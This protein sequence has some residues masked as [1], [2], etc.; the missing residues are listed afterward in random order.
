MGSQQF[1]RNFAIVAHIDHGKSTLADRLLEATGTIEP[2]LMMEQ[3]LDSNPIE[4]ERGITIKLAPVRMEYRYHNENYILNL[5]DTPGH[6]DFSYEV[7]RS[8]SACEGVLL[9]VDA[10]HGIQAQT[11]A[12]MKLVKEIGLKVIPIVNKIDLPAAKI[13]E[14]K[15]S[16]YQTFGFK[17]EE[18]IEVSAKKGIN[19]DKVLEEVILRIP[20]P[21]IDSG[22]QTR[23]L[24]FSSVYDPH[25]GVVIYV[26]VFNQEIKKVPLRLYASNTTFTPIELG[27]FTPQMKPANTLAAGE[28]GYVASGL[29]DLSLAKIGD[30]IGFADQ[31]FIPLPGF[32]EPKPMVFLSLYPLDNNNFLLLRQSLEK[33]HL[34][35]SSFTYTLHSSAALGKGYLC[36]FLGLLHADIMR[37]RLSREFGI[38]TIAASPS[39]EYKIKINSQATLIIHSPQDF[40][41]P[42]SIR[43]I[44]EP[45]MYTTIYTPTTT[46]GAVMQLCQEKR[47][48][49]IN[50]EYIADQAIFT[51]LIPLAEIIFDFYDLLKSLS[52]GYASLDYEFFEYRKVDAVKLDILLNREK[53]DAFSQIVVNQ[54]ADK[55]AEKLVHKLKNLIPRHQFEIPIQ[56]AIGGKII[57]RSD[58]KAFRKD[59]T[60]KLYGGDRTRKDKLLEAQKKGKKRMRQFGKVEIPQ[61]V[62]L[63]IYK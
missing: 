52:S 44:T 7:S 48:E 5:I 23:G 11:L 26:R 24:V 61:N 10:T 35:D 59:V 43:E 55:I 1:I 6:V 38:E 13:N 3:I 53:I 30:T 56:A 34:S 54:N 8:L 9:V 41:N 32:K 60:Q 12:H 29:K 2:R 28:V 51:Y 45:I 14:V 33:L 40:P 36:G 20:S 25:K 17:T 16:L 50:L 37:E 31:T 49:L 63:Q 19:I 42:S 27:F 47:G 21:A 22:Q 57:A 4:R 15:N 46:I 62:F 39:V 58:I 18:I